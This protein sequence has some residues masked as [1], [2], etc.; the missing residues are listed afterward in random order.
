[1]FPLMR[2]ECNRRIRRLFVEEAEVL[3]VV[4]IVTVVAIVGCVVYAAARPF[5][6]VHY[7][8]LNE[9]LWRPLD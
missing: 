7:H 6:H 2:G 8:R 4:V 3:T 1:M 5:T 9:R